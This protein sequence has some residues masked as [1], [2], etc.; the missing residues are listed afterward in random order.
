MKTDKRLDFIFGNL[1]PIEML[2]I[3]LDDFQFWNDHLPGV[4]SS[5]SKCYSNTLE[6][7]LKHTQVI[8][9]LSEEYNC[10]PKKIF[11]VL[12]LHGMSKWSILSMIFKF[13]WVF[14]SFIIFKCFDYETKPFIKASLLTVFIALPTDPPSKVWILFINFIFPSEKRRPTTTM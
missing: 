13:S 12:K 1:L 11:G 10:Y 5:H 14:Y 3:M 6:K 8:L 2:Q 4:V 9:C 7:Q